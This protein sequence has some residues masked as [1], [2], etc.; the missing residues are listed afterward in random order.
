MKEATL[1]ERTQRRE[2]CHFQTYYRYTRKYPS[3]D[4]ANTASRYSQVLR[5]H[6][7][8]D[9]EAWKIILK[10][11]PNVHVIRDGPIDAWVKNAFAVMHHACTTAVECTISRKPL[12]TFAA[13][14]LKDHIYQNDLAN[15]LGYVVDTK[16][17]LLN[18][19]ND[20][21]DESKNNTQKNNFQ[22]LPSLVSKKV[23]IEGLNLVF[24]IS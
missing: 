15:Q 7:S 14:E 1:R 2:R 4:S 20:L 11:I 21:Y 10:G 5:P 13:K 17:S 8:E 19:I 18:K 12:V 24:S 22:L 23:F 9:I 3:T 16:E 6:P